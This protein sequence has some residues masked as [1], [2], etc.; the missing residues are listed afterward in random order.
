VPGVGQPALVDA[1]EIAQLLG[2]RDGQQ[3]LDLRLHRLGFPQPVG[4]R[5]RALVWLRAEIEAWSAGGPPP[6]EG[7]P[8]EGEPEERGPKEGEAVNDE[9]HL[10][11][12]EPS[13]SRDTAE[14]LRP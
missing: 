9:D 1:R 4:R 13:S 14:T 12:T 7:G 8:E 2:L 10:P 3:V 11:V 5:H 6:G